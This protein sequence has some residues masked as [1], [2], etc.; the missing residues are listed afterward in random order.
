MDT[1]FKELNYF[2]RTD[3]AVVDQN[4]EMDDMYNLYGD[5]HGDADYIIAETPTGRRFAHYV[6]VLTYP[7]GTLASDGPITSARLEELAFHLNN[8]KP[9]LDE[10]LWHEIDPAYG[11]EAYISQGTEETNRLREIEE[12]VGE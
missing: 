1:N 2:V 9:E 7:N 6:V 5:I 10:D 8:T 4:T 11:S 3:I 12:A